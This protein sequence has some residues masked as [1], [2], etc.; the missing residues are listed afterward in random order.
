MSGRCWPNSRDPD[1]LLRRGAPRPR[2][3]GTER[4]T[5]SRPFPV[6]GLDEVLDIQP[7]RIRLAM[8]IAGFGMA[9]FAFWLQWYS[10]V[11]D[12][13]LNVG[14]RPLNSW[15]VFLLVPF[16]VGML[17]AALAGF[18]ALSWSLRPAAAA[19]SG[20]RGRRLRARDAGPFFP[21]RRSRLDGT[22]PNALRHAARR[23]RR[24]RRSRRCGREAGRLLL[25]AL[26][27]AGCT[28]Q[29]MRQQKR[30]DTYE[31]AALW[32]DGTAA[33][34]LPDGRRG[35]GRPRPRRSAGAAARR[36]RRSCCAAARSATRFSARPA[37]ASPATATA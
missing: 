34:P 9:A 29:S 2:A 27:L 35:A 22:P 26:A 10:A 6:D 14:G 12:Y 7:S 17:A 37:T 18:V 16:E 1:A 30:Y 33:R 25:A 15:P 32:P 8:L 21:A 19:P 23:L 24:A 31:P 20:V 4:S 28:D 36:S 5:R 11:F 3:T 13:P